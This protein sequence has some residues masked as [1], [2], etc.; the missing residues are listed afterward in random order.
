MYEGSFTPYPC[1]YVQ[2][3]MS[4]GGGEARRNAVQSGG[5]ARRS[6]VQSVLWKWF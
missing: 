4:S 3:D 5:E 2:E 1:G 6:T